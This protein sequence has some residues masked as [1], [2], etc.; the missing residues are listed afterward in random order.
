MQMSLNPA[1][2]IDDV[3]SPAPA[4]ARFLRP[5]FAAAAV[6]L[7]FTSID[8]YGSAFWNAPDP[9]RFVVLFVFAAG[10]LLALRARAPMPVLRSPLLRWALF[11]LLM[12]TAW[13]IWTASSPAASNALRA[14]FRSTGLLVAFAVLFDDA[15]ARRAGTLAVAAAVVFASLMNVAELTGF[16]P[17]EGQDNIRTAGRAAGLYVNPNEAGLAIVFGLAIVIGRVP[18]RWRLPLLIVGAAGVAPTFSRG[19]TICFVALILSVVSRKQVGIWPV[20]LVCAGILVFVTTHGEAVNRFLDGVLTTNTWGRLHFEHDD[21]GRAFLARKALRLF[22]G[23][24][25][26]GSG[27]G[28]AYESHN[29]FLALA[30]DHGVI[31]LL[32]FPALAMALVV[33]NP[34]GWPFSLVLMLAGIFSHNLLENRACLLAIAFAGAGR[35][36]FYPAAGARASSARVLE[37]GKAPTER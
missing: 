5:A 30:A 35:G 8:K 18:E 4:V 32:A 9:I 23:A 36:A 10:M 7:F 21:S 31:G 22:T 14:R 15:R 37:E 6:L 3:A 16:L 12:T 34:A 11:Y 27:L 1:P 19:A 25:L 13:A 26:L 29:E 2:V 33:A 28:A 20:A 17:F 24:P